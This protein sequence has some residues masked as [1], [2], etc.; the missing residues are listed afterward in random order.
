MQVSLEKFKGTIE[1][2]AIGLQMA[3]TEDVIC[4]SE[5]FQDNGMLVHLPIQFAS[6]VSEIEVCRGRGGPAGWQTA[7]HHS[8]VS[9]AC[10]ADDP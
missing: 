2:Y 5:T 1:K 8:R 10:L 4:E 6:R 3:L 9:I 7:P